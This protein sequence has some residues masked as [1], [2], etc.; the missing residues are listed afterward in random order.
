MVLAVRQQNICCSPAPSM[1]YSKM[2]SGQTTLPQPTN[3]TVAWGTYDV[4]P[5]SLRRLEFPLTNEK[6]KKDSLIKYNI[7]HPLSHLISL[8]TVFYLLIILF[9]AYAM[10]NT[11][12]NNTEKGAWWHVFALLIS[13][14]KCRKYHSKYLIL[15]NWKLPYVVFGV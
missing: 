15:I 2:E 1:S 10:A 7:L 6:K 8:N 11:G 4:L 5:P 13:T 3:S 14:D 12:S 9:P